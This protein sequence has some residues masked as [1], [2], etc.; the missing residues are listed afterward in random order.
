MDLFYYA[1]STNRPGNSHTSS[2]SLQNKKTT[3]YIASPE[4][5]RSSCMKKQRSYTCLQ[6]KCLSSTWPSRFHWVESPIYDC[7]KQG[8]RNKSIMFDNSEWERD[9]DNIDIPSV[10]R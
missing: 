7:Q 10:L 8:G 9:G 1:L 3:S 4:K 2:N 6:T 5:S